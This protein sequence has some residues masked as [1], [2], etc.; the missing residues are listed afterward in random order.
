VDEVWLE[1]E[2]ARLELVR[3]E[4]SMRCSSRKPSRKD[5]GD[6]LKGDVKTNP[7]SSLPAAL[8]AIKSSMRVR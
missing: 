3:L 1:E 2:L 4:E 5:G 6:V 7:L 8:A